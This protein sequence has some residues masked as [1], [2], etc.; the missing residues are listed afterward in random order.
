MDEKV[1]LGGI[2]ID[3]CFECH[4]PKKIKDKADII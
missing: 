2:N 4:K 3:E 1:G